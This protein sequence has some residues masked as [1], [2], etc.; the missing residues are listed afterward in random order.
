MNLILKTLFPN[1]KYEV[2]KM[3]EFPEGN[4]FW[5]KIASIYQIFNIDYELFPKEEA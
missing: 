5:A 1:K 4:M 2:G 3:I